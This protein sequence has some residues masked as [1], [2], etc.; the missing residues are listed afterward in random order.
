MF[1]FYIFFINVILFSAGSNVGSVVVQAPTQFFQDVSTLN[2]IKDV[3]KM[4]TKS[5]L[6]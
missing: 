4:H 6:A 5:Q 2:S 1:N 3:K